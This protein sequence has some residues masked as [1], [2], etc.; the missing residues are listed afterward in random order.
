MNSDPIYTWTIYRYNR[1]AGRD[2]DRGNFDGNWKSS[3]NGSYHDGSDY[4][5]RGYH[6]YDNRT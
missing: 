1:H 6:E 2:R 5:N 3:N 4:N